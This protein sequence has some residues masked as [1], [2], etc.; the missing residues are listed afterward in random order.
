MQS[1]V[2]R[3]AVNSDSARLARFG[4]LPD[5]Q[6]MRK[7]QIHRLISPLVVRVSRHSFLS[8]PRQSIF[9]ADRN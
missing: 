3:C 9:S 8:F 4:G 5:I 1:D 2:F 6:M 7:G